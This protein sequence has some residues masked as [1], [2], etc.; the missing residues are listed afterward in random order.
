MKPEKQTLHYAGRVVRPALLW[1]DTRSAA[2]AAA[3][4]DEVGAADFARRTGSVPV[5][6]FTLAKLRWLR[7]NE[8][9]NANRVAAGGA[10]E[11]ALAQL[12]FA[13]RT[14]IAVASIGF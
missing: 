8:P 12:G 6:S 1:N 4:T 13:V 3:L 10:I 2:A 5:A 9:G 14:Q 11:I 7:D